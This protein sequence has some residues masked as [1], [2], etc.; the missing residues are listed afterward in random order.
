VLLST[1]PREFPAHL[2]HMQTVSRLPEGALA[3]A[4]SSH[5]QH[6]IVRYGPNAMSTQF[7]PEFTPAIA[8][9]MIRQREEV[10]TEEG[11]DPRALLASVL[12]SPKPL[13]YCVVLCIRR[14]VVPFHNRMIW[15]RA[16]SFNKWLQLSR[17]SHFYLQIDL[18]IRKNKFRVGFDRAPLT[19]EPPPL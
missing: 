13:K 15:R 9:D 18:W 14:L 19:G 5:D 6:Q 10:L 1:L 17:G 2:T 4:S 16:R 11:F 8:A 3:L 12:P 7:H